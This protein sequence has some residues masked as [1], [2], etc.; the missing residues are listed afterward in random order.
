MCFSSACITVKRSSHEKTEIVEPPQIEAVKSIEISGEDGDVVTIPIEGPYYDPEAVNVAETL[1]NLSL[2][3]EEWKVKWRTLDPETKQLVEKLVHEL[4]C[5][6]ASILDVAFR[7]AKQ[8]SG[9]LD[10]KLIKDAAEIAQTL[11]K[12]VNKKE[13]SNKAQTFISTTI[14]N[15]VI[16]YILISEFERG[17]EN[18][19]SYTNGEYIPIGRYRFEVFDANASLIHSEPVLI[20]DDPTKKILLPLGVKR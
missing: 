17:F 18:W 19:S 15:C 20:F 7:V 9:P 8:T 1:Q 3:S 2:S 5:E 6:A 14:N 12:I 13:I 10:S 16:R 11:L 4:Y